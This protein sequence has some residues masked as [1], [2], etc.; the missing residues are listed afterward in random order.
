MPE[1]ELLGVD[2]HPAQVFHRGPEVLAG[3]QVLGGGGELGGGG[4]AGK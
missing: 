2:Q 4:L 1:Q 3:F